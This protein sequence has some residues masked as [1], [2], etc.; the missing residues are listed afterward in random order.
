MI[1]NCEYF[2]L[3]GSINNFVC[4]HKMFLKPILDVLGFA[5][6]LRFQPIQ[7][8]LVVVQVKL[9]DTRGSQTTTMDHRVTG[10]P[11]AADTRGK[12]AEWRY[13]K[14]IDD[15]LACGTNRS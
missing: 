3:Q 2:E 6:T 7:N 13:R 15:I 11:N 9:L 14:R 1:L 8:T 4:I 12:P 10:D 5:V